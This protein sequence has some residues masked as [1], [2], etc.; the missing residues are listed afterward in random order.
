MHNSAKRS[1]HCNG[2]N[3]MVSPAKQNI[4]YYF[5]CIHTY[6]IHIGNVTCLFL[7]LRV[8]EYVYK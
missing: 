2:G 5:V 1:F 8:D 4:W 3:P 7:Y 6:C